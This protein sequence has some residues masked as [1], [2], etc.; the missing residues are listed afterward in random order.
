[1][2]DPRY[3]TETTGRLRAVEAHLEDQ[4]DVLVLASC[5]GMLCLALVF[6]LAVLV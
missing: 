5:L 3:D 6:A 1:M 4:A 2:K